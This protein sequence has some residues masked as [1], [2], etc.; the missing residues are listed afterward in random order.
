L[1]ALSNCPYKG[2]TPLGDPKMES[3][4]RSLRYLWPYRGRIAVAILCVLVVAGL[5]SGGLGLMLPA[6]KILISDE[7]LHG[8][9]YNT[10]AQDRLGANTRH[11]AVSIAGR[12]PMLALQVTEVAQRAAQAGLRPSDWIIGLDDGRP[13]HALVGAVELARELTLAGSDK[14]VA[15]WVYDQREQTHRRVMVD[16]G[17]AKFTSS[18]LGQVALKIPEPRQFR[19]RFNMFVG[20]LAIVL[21]M[22]LLRAFFT[23]VQEYLIGT[24]VWRGIMDLRCDNYNVVLHL[25][26]VFFSEK[27]VSDATSR[28]IRDTSELAGGQNTLLGKTI[29]EPAKAIGL[30][31]I[32]LLCSWELTVMALVA[33]PPAFLLIRKFGKKMHRA[34]R[35]S[36]ESWS[37]M[38]AILGETLLGIRVVKSYTMEGAERRRFFRVNRQ[39]LRQQNRMER[40]DAATGPTVESLGVAAGMVAAGA[41]GYLVFTGMLD[42]DVF[43]TWMVMMFAIFDPV[44]KLAKVTMRFQQADAAAKRIFELQDT[45]QETR[46]P[47]APMLPRHRQTIEFRQVSFRYPGAADEAVKDVSFTVRA[48]QTVAIVGPNGSGKT[49]LVS[50]I[51][52]LFDP[53]AG[54][55]LIDGV[56]ISQCSMRSLRRQIGLVT[57]DTVIFAATIGENISYGLR[58]PDRKDVLAAAGKAFVDEFV[59]ELP[60]GY[61]TMVGEYGATLSGGQRQRIAIARAI[62]RDPAILILDEAMSQ[63]DSDSERRIHQATAE[64]VKGRTTFLIAHRFATVLAAE[65]I[66]VMNGGRVTDMGSHQQLLDR[67]ELYRHLYR[68]Q[69]VDTGGQAA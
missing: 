14:A 45:Q 37:M 64:F 66:V 17:P 4:L 24:A 43:L 55:I 8:W 39:L 68:T 20:L 53:T 38:L 22:T 41:A 27:G 65:T 10:V 47:A 13:E 23:F 44:R 21:V 7:G 58:R 28:F 57:Q 42:R 1:T 31:A 62:L 48:G 36:L 60:D 69:F 29:V 30:L 46:I 67:C 34:S 35:R 40:L 61:D 16:L 3:F 6:A 49:T 25:P 11:S 12:P 15:L 54:A 56:D 52:R 63:V 51:P 19:D 50:M 33:G 18:L 32:A 9:A 59:R 26:T 5:W 2:Q